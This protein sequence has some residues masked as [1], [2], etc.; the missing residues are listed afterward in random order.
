VKLAVDAI[1]VGER[2][3]QEMGD[4]DA[5]AGS[6]ERYGL[7]HPV[8]VDAEHHLVAGGR[9]LEACRRLGWPHIDVRDMGELTEAERREIE[10]E[11]NLRR[12][13]LTEY[14]RSRDLSRLAE[15]VAEVLVNE[16]RPES[17][18]KSR[19]QPKRPASSRAVAERIGVPRTTIQEAQTHVE[20]ADAYP[21]MQTWKQYEVLEAHDALAK[22]PETERPVVAALI[23]QPGIPPK[24][25]IEIVRNVAS[26]A[27][28]ER[29]RIYELAESSDSRDRTRALTDAAAKPPMPDPRLALLDD[30]AQTLRKVIRMFPGDAANPALTQVLKCLEPAYLAVKE[31]R[32]G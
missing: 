4:I 2:R 5:L 13:D 17:G 20:V 25:A 29:T 6:I 11:E 18:Q 3:R 30:V 10:L 31:A 22:L 14:E 28:P 1:V 27:E 7:L 24:A 32:R 21:F 8:V 12:K 23:E 16:Y 19:G 15:T 9:R 26:K